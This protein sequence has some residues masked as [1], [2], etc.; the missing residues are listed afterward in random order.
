MAHK[1]PQK[2]NST[3]EHWIYGYHATVGVLRNPKRIIRRILVTKS[4]L[5]ELE[6]HSISLSGLPV[7]IASGLEIEQRVG[8]AAVHQGI[9]ILVDPLP[10]LDIANILEL[11]QE[12]QIVIL[13][14]QVTD[15]HNV[16]AILRSAAAFGATAIITTDR[17]SA[18]MG[19][20]LAKAAS[21]ALEH[22]PLIHVTNLVR[23]MEDLQHAGFWCV[24]LAEEGKSLIDNQDF[25]GKWAVVL[26][27]EGKGLRRLIKETCDY[28]VRLPTVS[29]F[30]TLNV[31]N[32]AAVFLYDIF[33]KQ[34][35][36]KS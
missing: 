14:D 21:G 3:S 10:S 36:E 30:T 11:K 29:T 2:N 32:A 17:H 7:E 22:V 12:N 19:G 4:F 33:R 1:F 24:G 25:S 9:A 18:H 34:H 20:V 8:P 5:Q 35:K 13:L 28:L 23:A 15:P 31:S 27:A 26:G 16:G 6:E